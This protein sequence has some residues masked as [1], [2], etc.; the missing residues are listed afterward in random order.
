MDIHIDVSGITQLAAKF[1]DPDRVI[2][3]VAAGMEVGLAQTANN[4]V[5]SELSGQVL[6]IRSGRLAQAVEAVKVQISGTGVEG[7]IG[8]PFYGG[9]QEHGATIAVN[10]AVDLGGDI[11]WRHLDTVTLPARPWLE[12][13]VKENLPVI[14]AAITA[15]V[16]ASLAEG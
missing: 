10:S 7:T 3:A 11:G 2:A 9:V 13:G 1:E 14:E 15:A 4:I 6:N 16:L 12:P 8:G 5:G